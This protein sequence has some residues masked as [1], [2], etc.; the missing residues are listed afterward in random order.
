MPTVTRVPQKTKRRQ[1]KSSQ[2]SPARLPPVFPASPIEGKTRGSPGSHTKRQGVTKSG[3][4]GPGHAPFPHV[5][6]SLRLLGERGCGGCWDTPWPTCSV[7]DEV[8]ALSSP[9]DD[10]GVEGHRITY[11]LSCYALVL[12]LRPQERQ[13][14]A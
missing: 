12:S 2:E 5:D 7:C 13:V 6:H 4:K 3:G 14:S 8:A 11:C 9:W 10:G 1:A